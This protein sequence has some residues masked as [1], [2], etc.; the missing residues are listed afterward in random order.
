MENWLVWKDKGCRKNSHRFTCCQ[1]SVYKYEYLTISDTLI[2]PEEQNEVTANTFFNVR[3][4][5]ISPQ[6]GDRHCEWMG[7]KSSIC[8]LTFLIFKVRVFCSWRILDGWKKTFTYPSSDSMT[9]KVTLLPSETL[10]LE[11]YATIHN[12][13]SLPLSCWTTFSSL[14]VRDSWCQMRLRKVKSRL[15]S[16]SSMWAELG[17]TFMFI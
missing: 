11:N 4:D 1:A 9:G 10:S 3:N 16:Y 15:W 6:G 17:F 2:V 7:L 8:Q 5:I 14:R 12:D 13:T